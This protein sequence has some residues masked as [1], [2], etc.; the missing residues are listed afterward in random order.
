MFRTRN[1]PIPSGKLDKRNALIFGVSISILGIVYLFYF[2]N[3]S[4]SFLAFLTTIIYLFIYTPFKKVSAW[5]L[6]VG[7]IPGAIPPFG[8]WIAATGNVELPA[9]VLFAI[10]FFW[11]IPHFLAISILYKDDYKRGGFVGFPGEENNWKITNI[12][13]LLFSSALI[14]ASISLSIIGITGY[15][16]ALF[17]MIIGVYFLAISGKTVTNHSSKQTKKLL[18]ASICYLPILMGITIL[19]TFIK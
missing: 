10:L 6:M 2:V 8:G 7:A 4:V 13:I 1:R 17:S 15:F 9:W 16:Y 11:Q 18:I 19:D 3:P 5:S 14:I 12:N